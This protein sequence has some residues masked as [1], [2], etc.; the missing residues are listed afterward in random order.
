MKYEEIIGPYEYFQPVVDITEEKGDY[1]KRFIPTKDFLEILR[2]FLNAL[3]SKDSNRKSIWIQG[4]YGTGKSHATSVIKH[5]LWDPPE[6][7]G[8]FVEKI[9]AQIREKLRNFRKEKRVFPVVLKGISG[10]KDV[11][12]FGLLLEKA[13]KEAL[14]REKIEIITESEFDKYINHIK[15]I[16]Y[17]DYEQIIEENIELKAKVRNKEGLLNALQR[18]DIDVL[19]LLENSLDFSIPHSTIED[20]LV[21]VSRELSSKGIYALTIYWDEF[22]SLMELEN[23]STIMSILQNIAEKT[24]NNNIFLFIVS[25]RA[26][27]QSSV[28]S[29][30]YEKLLGRFHFKEYSMENITTFHI[31]S[32]A[33]RKIDSERWENLREEI[34]RKNP[35]IEKLIYRIARYDNRSINALKDLFPIHPYSAFIATALSRYVGSAERSI[36][37]FLNDEEKGFKKFISE[38]PKSNLDDEEYFLTPDM[39]WDFFLA[40]FERNPNEKRSSV[41]V[42]YRQCEEVIEEAGEPYLAVFK[43]TL[44]LN[45][46]YSLI[47]VSGEESNLYSPSKEN[48]TNM[49]IGTSFQDSVPEILDYIDKKGYVPKNPDGLFLVSYSALPEKEV[50]EERQIVSIE[51]KDITRALSKHQKERLCRDLTSN[52]LR[53]NK[54]QVYW[55]GIKDYD[56]RRKLKNDF[57]NSYYLPIALFIAKDGDEIKNIENI[58]EKIFADKDVNYENIIFVI[59]NTPLTKESYKKFTD[60]IAKLIVAERHQYREDAKNYR[61]YREKLIEQWIDKVKNGYFEVYFKQEFKQLPGKNLDSYL[62]KDVSSKI[63]CY[64]LENLKDLTNINVWKRR[65]SDKVLEIFIS[66][67]DRDDLEERTKNAPYKDLRAILTD[68]RGNYI[69]DKKLNFLSNIDINHHPTYK[70]CKD[71]E[72]TIKKHEGKS[73]NLG[74]ELRF[75]QEP[76]YGIYPNMANCAVLA[77]AMRP[78]VDKLYEEGT[79]RKIDKNLLKEKLGILFK[80]WEDWK[81]REKLN[82]RLGTEEER[83][84]TDLLVELFKLKEEENLN[85]ARW[86][87]REWIKEAGYPIWSLRNHVRDDKEMERSIDMIFS[88]S[89]T[90]DGEISEESIKESFRILSFKKN[91]LGTLLSP[92]KLKEGFRKWVEE[93]LKREITEEDFKNLVVF[94][95][96]NMQE[97]VGLWTEDKVELKLKDWEVDIGTEKAERE[98]VN[99]ISKIFNLEQVNNLEDLKRGVQNKINDLGFPLWILKHAFNTED[100]GKALDDIDN[101]VKGIPVNS[102]ALTEF[103]NDIRPYETH[104]H[105]KLT[106]EIAKQGLAV[107]LKERHSLDLDLHSFIPY[108]RNRIDKNRTD[109]EPYLWDETDLEI[110]VREYNI[111]KA[112][113]EIFDIDEI[114]PIEELKVEIKRKIENLSYPF[115]LLELTEDGGSIFTNIGEF[116]RSPYIPP[117]EELESIVNDVSGEKAREFL[118]ENKLKE[119]AIRWLDTQLKERFELKA[120]LEDYILNEILEEMRRNICPEDFYWNRNAVENWIYK[121]EDL[122]Y[123]IFKNIQEEVKQKIVS[124]TKDLKEVLLKIVE[125]Y[126]EICVKLEE[127]L[128]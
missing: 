45:I 71:I 103:L 105:S 35:G 5:L 81:N 24:R 42:K 101:F 6:D 18:R 1:W 33:I 69:V 89:M 85:K 51:H 55:A 126:P 59:S 107:F 52:I 124:S 11:K 41:L 37:S 117:V 22:T 2:V 9:N 8:D 99:L 34:F 12:S 86:G 100:M 50:D 49:F 40:E 122:N 76:P 114:L 79:G 96:E 10:I 92:Q 123:K 58:I 125:E 29:K 4:S 106:S 7:I 84:L 31:V 109:K 90:V 61:D 23:I 91:E 28:S 82:L 83:K 80:Y 57:K 27:Q 88:L 30:D 120:S 53:E 17:V 73:F 67:Q 14:Q 74:D 116:L 98:F 65:Y 72:K 70:I 119:L 46:L 112:L 47:N 77:F 108:L 87:I 64:G 68:N 38:Y 128:E 32:N 78:F 66:A 75:L 60:Y 44:L 121:N 104:I 13:V 102:E 97:E 3:E 19:R 15:N 95:R 26:P 56:L 39:L 111:S 113:R 21:E 43:G 93:K 127:Y 115:W 48:I 25:H 20:W 54:L 16:P 63:F 94:L 118:R 36:F 110:V 62:N